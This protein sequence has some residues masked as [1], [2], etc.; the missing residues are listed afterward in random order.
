MLTD[1]CDRGVYQTSRLFSPFQRAHTISPVLIVVSLPGKRQIRLAAGSTE[2]SM[3]T[4]SRPKC[5]VQ[6]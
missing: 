3:V 4:Q 6:V 2:T 5:S 1:I